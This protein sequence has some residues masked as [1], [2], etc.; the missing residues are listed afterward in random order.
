MAIKI[1]GLITAA[2][3]VLLFILAKKRPPAMPEGVF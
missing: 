2:C 1:I 3:A